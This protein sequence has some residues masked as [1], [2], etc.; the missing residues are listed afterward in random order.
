MIGWANSI[1]LSDRENLYLVVIQVDEITDA[2]ANQTTREQRDIRDRA[3]VGIRLVLA[4]N[5][6]GLTS[7]VVANDR[8]AMAECD[9]LDGRRFRPKCSARKTFGEI[10]RVARSEFK[11]AT[12]LARTLY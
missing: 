8:D 11:R 3:D 4:N 1:P 12:A 10:A 2:F 6:I 9:D 5:L 7:V